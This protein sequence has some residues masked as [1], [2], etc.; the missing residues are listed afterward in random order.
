M[1][2]LARLSRAVGSKVSGKF[3]GCWARKQS[4]EESGGASGV[5]CGAEAR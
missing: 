3:F 5:Y 2:R 4:E 1:K